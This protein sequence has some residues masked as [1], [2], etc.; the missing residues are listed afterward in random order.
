VTFELLTFLVTFI[1][2][3]LQFKRA[4]GD[5]FNVDPDRL[6]VIVEKQDLKDEVYLSDNKIEEGAK[7]FV[8]IR[9]D[10]QVNT[11]KTM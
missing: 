4:I 7:V 1:V 8:V 6:R 3:Y 2:L 5:A 9:P 11:S 10:K